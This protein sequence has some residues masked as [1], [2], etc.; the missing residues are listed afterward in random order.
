MIFLSV[1]VF[2]PLPYLPL[3]MHIFLLKIAGQCFD[4]GAGFCD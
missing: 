1:P 2:F 4:A 3:P